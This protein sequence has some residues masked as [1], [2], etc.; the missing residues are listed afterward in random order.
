MTGDEVMKSAINY[1][2]DG[3]V[4]LEMYLHENPE[5]PLPAIISLPGGAF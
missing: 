5:E 2:V 1:T 4:N 3:R